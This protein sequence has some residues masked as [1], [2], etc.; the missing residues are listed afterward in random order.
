[1]FIESSPIRS[2]S[3]PKPCVLSRKFS[4]NKLIVMKKAASRTFPAR[5]ISELDFHRLGNLDVIDFA[6]QV[7]SHEEK[8]GGLSL[9][10]KIKNAIFV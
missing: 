2:K 3:Q 4:A 1:V 8:N 10:R 9:R 5:S 6:G 7:E